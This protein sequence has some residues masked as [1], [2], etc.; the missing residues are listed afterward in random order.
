MMDELTAIRS[1]LAPPS[2]TFWKWSDDG[3]VIA[4]A[5]NRT[6][7][8]RGELQIV[9]ER[10]ATRGLPPLGAVVL[11]LAACRD[12]WGD[13]SEN[14][15]ILHGVLEQ[16]LVS[17]VSQSREIDD[18]RRTLETVLQH[19]DRVGTVLGES[20]NDPHVKAAL[21]DVVFETVR[22]RTSPDAA[23]AVVTALA[24]GALRLGDG[25]LLQLRHLKLHHFLSDLRLLIPGP[26]RLD[27]DALRLRIETGLDTEVVAAEVEE[28]LGRKVRRLFSQL[29][30]DVELA[31]VARLARNLMAVAH[32][33]RP[34]DEYDD[35]PVGGVSDISNRGTLDRLLIS[36]LAQDDETLMLRVAMNEALYLRRETPPR[37]PPRSRAVVVDAGLRLWGTP[38]VFATSV[39]LSLAATS[40]RNVDVRVFRPDGERLASVDLSTRAG[41]VEHLKALCPEAHPGR[42]LPELKRSVE[43]AA[44]ETDTVLITGADVAADPE[45]QRDLNAYGEEI[46]FVITVS[47]TGE[48][49]LLE[50]MPHG[51]KVL[52]TATMELERLLGPAARPTAPLVD[53]EFSS[54]VPAI[55]RVAPF[56]LL[57]PHHI[58]ACQ[59]WR[60]GTESVLSVTNDGRLMH[61]KPKQHGRRSLAAQQFGVGLPSRHILWR[62]A[63]L[64]EGFTQFIVGTPGGDEAW[65]VNVIFDKQEC[66]VAPLATGEA[67]VAGICD[68]AGALFV[69]HGDSIDVCNATLGFRVQTCPIP[70]GYLWSNARFFKTP[71]GWSALSYDGTTARF[72]EVVNYSQFADTWQIAAMFDVEGIEG[73]VGLLKGDGSLYFTAERRLQRLS[74]ACPAPV[75]PRAASLDGR[76]ICV[77]QKQLS[78]ER[79]L[80]LIDAATG[81]A[82]PVSGDPQAAV[83]QGVLSS[84]PSR[85]LRSRITA[86]GVVARWIVLK[87]QKNRLLWLLHD[88]K[89]DRLYLAERIDAEVIQSRVK[90]LEPVAM[91]HPY[92]Q[93][94]LAAAWADGS[95]IILDSRGML[96]LRSG[97]AGIP[98]LTLVL[99]DPHVAGW[100]A[101]GRMW[102]QTYFLGDHRRTSP[103]E[104]WNDVLRPF[105]KRLMT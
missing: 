23:S 65:L 21:I 33:P 13:T 7:V 48:F 90:P 102:G 70:Q 47:R 39:A 63:R 28:P 12:G 35:M 83:D 66:R 53:S 57:I 76:R 51:T 32:L 26:E 10:Q 74:P 30:H 97:D 94:M 2:G 9:L 60:V 101:D 42:S 81:E 8:F 104:I 14:A 85:T 6:I 71:S 58:V 16:L 52:R 55:L 86:I 68:H 45:F 84:L 103:R 19:L 79:G 50:R 77:Q 41:L 44:R 3:E 99:Y 34:L 1:Y 78:A 67:P 38:R 49:Q 29:E 20:R 62:R 5:D 88:E 27:A 95:R 56:P 100:C 4:W 54:D 25:P 24:E 11:L 93:G 69:I 105:T 61:W 36:E 96:H 17:V 18:A 89:H 87:T 43:E 46:G 75:V 98:E 91:E 37:H 22:E 73:P 82:S 64:Y 72:E 59:T 92:E 40:D 80:L 15:G 31:G